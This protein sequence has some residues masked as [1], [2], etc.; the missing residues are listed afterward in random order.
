LLIIIHLKEK[1]K[2]FFKKISTISTIFSTVLFEAC[3]GPGFGV[4]KKLHKDFEGSLIDRG[5]K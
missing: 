2:C 4:E 1:C 3:M 5:S